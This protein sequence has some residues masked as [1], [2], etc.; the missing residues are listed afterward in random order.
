MQAEEAVEIDHRIARNIDAGPHGVITLLAVRHH[1]IQS[2]SRAA[3][4]NDDKRLLP[5]WVSA[6]PIA[7]RAR[8]LGTAAVPTTAI[9]LLRR[10]T[11]RVI[12][13]KQLL[14]AIS[15]ETPASPAANP[16]SCLRRDA[17]NRR[18]LAPAFCSASP[19]IRSLLRRSL[20]RV[21]AAWIRVYPA[22]LPRSLIDS[23]APLSSRASA[24][25]VAASRFFQR[26][27]RRRRIRGRSRG[28]L[29][30]AICAASTF[31]PL[32]LPRSKPAQNSCG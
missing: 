8:K 17:L 22:A 32:I 10:N 11:R 30:P 27:Q 12:D 28:A 31:T 18:S 9:A 26:R 6:A 2:I 5:A 4:E 1:D 25:H 15:S 7:A 13:I 19:A 16:R 3:L 14:A 24:G 23:S 20:P 29:L 21:F